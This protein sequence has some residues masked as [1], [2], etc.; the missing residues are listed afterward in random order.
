MDSIGDRNARRPILAAAVFLAAV[1]ITLPGFAQPGHARLDVTQPR[2]AVPVMGEGF[3]SDDLRRPAAPSYDVVALRVEFQPDTTRF[4]TGDGTFGGDLYGGLEPSVDPLPHDAAYF[5]AHL[6]FLEDYVARVSDGATVVR[7]HLVPE[8]VRLPERMGAYAPTGSDADSDT[9]RARL[10]RLVHEAWTLADV[11]SDFDMGGFTAGRTAFV[12]FHAGVGRDVELI[13][14]TLDKTPEDLPSIFFGEDALERLGAGGARFNGFPVDHSM[15][16]PRTETRIGTDFIADEPYLL[17]LSING[18]LA[19]SFLNFL[20]VPDLFDVDSGRSAIGPFG[21]MDAQGIFAYSGLFPPEPMAWT[22]YFLGWTEP[23]DLDGNGPETVWLGATSLPGRSES[24]RALVSGAEYF[25]VE[26]RYRDPE[27]DGLTLRVWK[28]G[29]I[30]EQHV[31]NGDEQFNSS[32]ISGFIGGVV[33]GVDNYDWAL[34]GGLDEAGNELNGGL[35]IWHVDERRLRSGLAENAV[36]VGPSRAIDLEEADGAQDV[37]FPSSNP[38]APRADLGTPFDFFFEGNPVYVETAAG[39]ELRLYENRFGPDTFPGSETNAGGPSFVILED[40]SEPGT[41]MSF[42]YRR[43]GV[44]GIAPLDEPALGGLSEGLSH[45]GE[46]SK[47]TWSG[48]YLVVFGGD[49]VIVARTGREEPV[50][51]T[52]SA[53]VPAVVPDGRI[54]TLEGEPGS[55]R[56]VLRALEN[57]GGEGTT[58]VLPLELGTRTPASPIVYADSDGTESYHLLFEG[59]DG[60]VHV[61]AS[62]AGSDIVSTVA[63]IGLAGRRDPARGILPVAFRRDGVEMDG[64][65]WVYD[66]PPGEAVG[67]P[68]AGV[69]REGP[70]AAIPIT[71]RGEL[72]VLTAGGRTLRIDVAAA[73]GLPAESES[74]L[75]G[76]PLLSDLDGDG[77]LDVLVAI[78]RHLVALSQSGALLEGFPIRTPARLKGQPIVFQFEGEEAWTVLSAAADGHLYAHGMEGGAVDG[79]PLEVGGSAAATPVIAESR[80]VAVSAEGQARGWELRPVR[81]A[82][83]GSLYGSEGNGSFVALDASDDEPPGFDGLIDES[84]TYNWP[85]PIDEG[86]THLRIRT[87]EDARVEITILD[88]GGGHVDELEMGPVAGGV[89]AELVWQADVQSGLYFARFTATTTAGRR[90][91]RLIKMAVIR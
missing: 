63:P 17:E 48:E 50:G 88:A 14:T 16:V 9:E 55:Y 54:A 6:S 69:E 60:S 85:N 71:E 29:A 10:A 61:R 36:N 30:A 81:R 74:R 79:F 62:A 31:E 75:S 46:D 68:V 33:V 84:E 56:V 35:L 5:R 15:V 45:V 11:Q 72:I 8:V 57:V 59:E 76:L 40:F 12:L 3:P 65:A 26:N 87:A 7:T 32:V 66:V 51:R 34:P 77:R 91:S 47:V 64:V 28:D 37:G 25:F 86:L 80:L 90:E 67:Q 19:A 18:M 83:W 78:G 73:A 1:L 82:W 44:F 89:P 13:G 52:A 24:A 70:V 22:K 41:E 27:Q 53:A 21:L 23:M 2:V 4:T 49:S 58:Y 39:R 42:V 43:E 38:F 20:G